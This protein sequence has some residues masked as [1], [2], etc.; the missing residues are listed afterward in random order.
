MAGSVR[1]ALGHR[2]RA[3]GGGVRRRSEAGK[4]AAMGLLRVASRSLLRPGPRAGVGAAVPRPWRR[5]HNSYR[6][7]GVLV[8]LAGGLVERGMVRSMTGPSAGDPKVTRTRQ[9]TCTLGADGSARQ[10][11]ESSLDAG[12]TR[13]VLFDGRDVRAKGAP[14][15]PQAGSASRSRSARASSGALG[16][17]A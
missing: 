2:A 15:R 7:S 14:A 6:S 13:I 17:K 5:R 12:R 3:S 11:W 16:P 9:V 1:D 4:N 8:M 10:P